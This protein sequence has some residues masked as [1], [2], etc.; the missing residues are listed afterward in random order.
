EIRKYLYYRA[1]IPYLATT[2]IVSLIYVGCFNS[3]AQTYPTVSFG[4]NQ[5]AVLVMMVVISIIVM[6]LYFKTQRPLLM[7][8]YSDTLF[9]LIVIFSPAYYSVI[10]KFSLKSGNLIFFSAYLLFGVGMIFRYIL[11]IKSNKK[12]DIC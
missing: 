12:I 6:T 7:S 2:I 11:E 10:D 9:Y 4:F 3:L 8:N 5:L 1:L